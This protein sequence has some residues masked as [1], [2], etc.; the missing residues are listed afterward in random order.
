[1][2]SLLPAWLH[3]LGLKVVQRH[4]WEE[5]GGKSGAYRQ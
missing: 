5:K 1:M 3:C 2:S 4:S